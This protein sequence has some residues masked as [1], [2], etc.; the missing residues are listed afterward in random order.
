MF[1]R[2]LHLFS[3]LAVQQRWLIFFSVVFFWSAAG[4]GHE[5]ENSTF[6]HQS[7]NDMQEESEIAQEN[8][9]NSILVMF[10]DKD[11]P[12]CEKMKQTVFTEQTVKQYYQKHFRIIQI[13][14]KGDAMMNDFTGKELAEKEFAFKQHR[15]RATP[16]FIFFDLDGNPVKRYTGTTRNADEFLLLGQYVVDKKYQSISFSK[17]KRQN[18]AV[19]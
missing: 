15:V 1:S 19:K 8:N 2:F 5:N 18:T 11:C 16:V 4:F 12:W 7:F 10:S 17:Y 3:P 13:D 6:F 14:V 9:Q